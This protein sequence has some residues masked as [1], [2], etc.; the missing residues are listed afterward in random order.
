V[1]SALT[2]NY[3]QEQ[4]SLSR[5]KCFHDIVFALLSG[6]KLVL[7]IHRNIEE[8]NHSPSGVESLKYSIVVARQPDCAAS[9]S[10][11]W[12]TRRPKAHSLPMAGDLSRHMRS[13]NVVQH[14]R[15]I[16]QL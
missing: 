6:Q 2:A 13:R 15:R 11:M 10:L 5:L 1:I 8:E 14:K 16:A 4:H 12:M 7:Q 3:D 9:P